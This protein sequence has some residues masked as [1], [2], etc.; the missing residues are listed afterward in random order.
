VNLEGEG[1]ES[2]ALFS[3]EKKSRWVFFDKN[4]KKLRIPSLWTR[5]SRLLTRLGIQ[6]VNLHTWR[7][8]F[9]S[10]L[11]MGRATSARSRSS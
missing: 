2:F 3:G 7:H 8:T 1:A 10:Y 11:M 9:A 4:G 5:F 6:N